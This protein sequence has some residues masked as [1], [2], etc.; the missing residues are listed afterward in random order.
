MFIN[1]KYLYKFMLIPSS[2]RTR[3]L[4]HKRAVNAGEST[5]MHK[6][7]RTFAVRIHGS[8]DE[9][10]VSAKGTTWHVTDQATHPPG[11]IRVN[12]GSAIGSQGSNV[13]S[14]GKLRLI[15]G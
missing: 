9:F 15:P 2:S 12:D 10:D 3:Y 1:S 6:L 14:Y 5:Y 4:F 8:M 7:A 13:S 11:L